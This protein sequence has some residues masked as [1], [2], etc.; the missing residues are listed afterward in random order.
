MAPRHDLA[1]SLD[2]HAPAAQLKPGDQF[3]AIERVV[4]SARFA[5]DGYRDHER[6]RAGTKTAARHIVRSAAVPF[7]RMATVSQLLQCRSD[8]PLQIPAVRL[9]VD[10]GVAR[11]RRPGVTGRY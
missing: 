9:P 5:V 7:Y 1:V 10:M 6:V 3:G 8:L 11:G 2:R 4:E